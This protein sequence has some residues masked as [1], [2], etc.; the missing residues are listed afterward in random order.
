M[1][2]GLKALKYIEEILDVEQIQFKGLQICCM[3]HL[4]TKRCSRNYLRRKGFKGYSVLSSYFN[5]IGAIA[6]EIDINTKGIALP[7]DLGRPIQD[8]S[9]FNKF[10][11]IIDGGTAEH[12]DNQKEYFK[13]VF[14][15]LKIGGIS[16]HML[17][18][19]YRWD[20]H[21]TWR[22]DTNWLISFIT[23]NKYLL[24]DYKKTND[25]YSAYDANRIILFWAMKKT[26]DT[27]IGR[28][29]NPIFDPQGSWKDKRMYNK[30]IIP[31]RSKNVSSN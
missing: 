23:N 10:D 17:P 31:A 28:I 26:K 14:N 19:R 27:I 20:R 8:T 3:G 18:Y 2:I 16:M 7:L 13:N 25:N 9:L 24:I 29:D 30:F 5:R 15:L 1:S 22:Y 21:S 12:I 6:T 11:L 4:N